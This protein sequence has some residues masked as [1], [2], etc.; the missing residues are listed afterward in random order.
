MRADTIFL[1]KPSSLGDIVHTLPSLHALRQSLPHSQFYWIVNSEWSPLLLGNP[2][3]KEI[4]P[5]P[6]QSFRGLVGVSKFLI[7]CR[8]LGQ[9]QP[10]LVLDFQGLLRS[11][12]IARSTRGKTLM[13]LSD[14]REGARFFYQ[15]TAHVNPQQHSVERYL[16]LASLAGAAIPEKAHFGLPPGRAIPEFE[17]PDRF[18]VLHPFARG[19]NKS[20][21]PSEIYELTRALAP[22]AVIV[23]GRAETDFRF[24]LNAASLVNQTDLLQ[25][26]WLLRRASFVISV[27][28]GPMHLAAA[29]SRQLLSIHF[30][31]DPKQVGPYRKDAWIWQNSHICRVRDLDDRPAKPASPVRPHPIQIGA[32]VQEQ[33]LQSP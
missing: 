22:L 20:L 7:W 8:E 4:I 28:S 15:E 13:G 29:V 21:S 12:W 32:F 19:A 10:D 14:A 23:V 30:W 24:A 17:L 2:D 26:I 33:L 31:S 9:Y 1:V 11:A 16:T 18:V 5:F 3:L 25:L 27:D 6:R